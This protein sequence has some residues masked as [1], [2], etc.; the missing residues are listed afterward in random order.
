M[1]QARYASWDYI[2]RAQRNRHFKEKHLESIKHMKKIAIERAS[3]SREHNMAVD[4]RDL[5]EELVDTIELL[6]VE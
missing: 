2:S 3:V 6:E 1:R 4:L 5:L